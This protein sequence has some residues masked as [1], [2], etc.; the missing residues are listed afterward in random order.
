M[1]FACVI[2]LTMWLV[3][4]RTGNGYF[5]RST[6]YLL[7][8]VW[9]FQ[10]FLPVEA[11]VLD[12]EV[13]GLGGRTAR[14][15]Q[16]SFQKREQLFTEQRRKVIYCY[17]IKSFSIEYELTR[18]F[19]RLTWKHLRVGMIHLRRWWWMLCLILTELIGKTANQESTSSS[20]KWLA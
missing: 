5:E 18:P 20:F 11:R 19:S 15:V 17:W 8:Q 10:G 9:L 16:I 7:I 4:G 13:W 1:R 12:V 14:E 6:T 2:G 3:C